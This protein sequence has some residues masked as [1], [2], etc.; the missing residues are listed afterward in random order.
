MYDLQYQVPHRIVGGPLTAYV[1]GK[2]LFCAVVQQVVRFCR[3]EALSD[4]LRACPVLETGH[5]FPL[6]DL[7][8]YLLTVLTEA[9]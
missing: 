3:H 5:C 7:L 6:S 9:F 1:H 4:S 2:G 8:A